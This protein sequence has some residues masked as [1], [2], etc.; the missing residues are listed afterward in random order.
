MQAWDEC[1]T[2]GKKYLDTY[3]ALSSDDEGMLG[4]VP[5]T[6]GT[7]AGPSY[8]NMATNSNVFKQ[9]LIHAQHLLLMVSTA[10]MVGTAYICQ[11][12]RDNE[13]IPVLPSTYVRRV[14]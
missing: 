14:C 8:K 1:E 12:L 7:A 6:E 4:D 3:A 10:C 5:G 9:P 2:A 11:V 13:W